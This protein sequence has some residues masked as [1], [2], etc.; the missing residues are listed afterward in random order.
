MVLGVSDC[1]IEAPNLFWELLDHTSE[2]LS[3]PFLKLSQDKLVLLRSGYFLSQA[4]LNKLYF[5]LK[6]FHFLV[7]DLERSIL[8]VD[9]CFMRDVVTLPLV[10]Y[11][12][13][14]L[15]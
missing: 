8:F 13:E 11:Y 2:L 14:L 10:F 6:I 4:F 9:L 1:Q 12:F 15:Q 3:D 7:I 5:V